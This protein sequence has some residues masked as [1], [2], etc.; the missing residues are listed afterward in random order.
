M[1]RGSPTFFAGYSAEN[2][3]VFIGVELRLEMIARLSG[4]ETRRERQ[5]ALGIEGKYHGWDYPTRSVLSTNWRSL[6]P[7]WCSERHDPKHLGALLEE[8]VH[9]RLFDVSR[10]QAAIAASTTACSTL[11]EAASRACMARPFTTVA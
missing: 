3:G 4:Y 9:A 2:H 5:A 11:L 1:T 6:S 7:N 8:L 10:S